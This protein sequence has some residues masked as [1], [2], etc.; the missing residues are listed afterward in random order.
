[1]AEMAKRKKI[2]KT[3]VA[4]RGRDDGGRVEKCEHLCEPIYEE[5]EAP[6]FVDLSAPDRYDPDSDR[7]W[8]CSRVGCDQ[9]HEEEIDSETIWKNFVLKVMAARSPNI[10]LRK[11]LSRKPFGV[12][13]KCP[14][15]APAKPLRS[16]MSRL[17]LLSST[18]SRKIAFEEEGT[19]SAPQRPKM[20][21]NKENRTAATSQALTTLK[22]R[23]QVSNECLLKSVRSTKARTNLAKSNKVA[24]K[25]L[26]FPSPKKTRRMPGTPELK[27]SV[28]SIC[29]GMKNLNLGTPRKNILGYEKKPKPS[30]GSSKRPAGRL[31]KSRVYDS[32]RLQNPKGNTNAEHSGDLKRKKIITN[33]LKE[34]LE[35]GESSDMEVE[36]KFS[37]G[38][39]EASNGAD[40]NKKDVASP[41]TPILTKTEHVD[42]E[43]CQCPLDASHIPTK[44][45]LEDYGNDECTRDEAAPCK[46]QRGQGDENEA[47]DTDD[48]E[49]TVAPNCCREQKDENNSDSIKKPLQHQ[50][51]PKV[52]QIRSRT[53]KENNAAAEKEKTQATKQTKPKPTNPKPFRLRTDERGIL[54]E[55]KLNTAPKETEGVSSNS[56]VNLPKSRVIVSKVN[57]KR[58]ARTPEDHA[59]VKEK[60]LPQK[61]DKLCSRDGLAPKM[62]RKPVFLLQL[63]LSKDNNRRNKSVTMKQLE[64]PRR[65]LTSKPEA[66]KGSPEADIGKKVPENSSKEGGCASSATKADNLGS[67]GPRSSS[68]TRRTPTIPKEPH[69]HEIHVP[70]SCTRKVN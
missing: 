56:C 51:T 40:A 66:T 50:K 55:A 42:L 2:G 38:S 9:K 68:R 35:S 4:R 8:F 46:V 22:N 25:S 28:R 37:H 20:P 49:N 3:T 52:T 39:I 70:K 43:L 5:I 58:F 18:V 31:V 54:K 62:Q 11:A 15:S 29:E 45:E 41:E 12:T 30:A 69:F 67:C 24:L 33:E 32:C 48:K 27:S 16:R 13:V 53:L 21:L 34:R 65:A 61:T 6:K 7:Y 60:K 10:R 59:M 1:M 23:A 47:F 36:R 19:E 14:Q 44:L 17:A 64:R 63:R 26:A 57:E